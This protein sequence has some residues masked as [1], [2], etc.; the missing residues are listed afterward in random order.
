MKLLVFFFISLFLFSHSCLAA[1]I[2]TQIHVL[3]NLKNFLSGSSINEIDNFDHNEC[4]REVVELVLL[5]QALELG[6]YKEK[7]DIR[8]KVVPY[9]R[10]PKILSGDKFTVLGESVWASEAGMENSIW[11]SGPVIDEKEYQV[12][13]YT[14]PDNKKALECKNLE[15]VR[16]L[17][18]VS[19]ANYPVDWHTLKSLNLSKLYDV[20]SWTTMVYMA[21]KMR[22]DFL[23]LPFQT[24][25]GM[26]F[27]YIDKNST[28]QLEKA[29]LVPIP[30][31]KIHLNGTRH[32]IVSKKNK[33]GSKAYTA[34][35]KGLEKLNAS[36]KR[37]RAFK[38]CGFIPPETKSW[39]LLN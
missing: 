19:S 18:A 30:N 12:G 28:V 20:Q 22:A 16:K 38:E 31:V 33:D 29:F 13:L 21:D 7:I 2:L 5:Y 4:L 39:A 35:Q 34:I 15:D 14:S 36:G 8:V 6:G 37:V 9:L 26:S 10:G 3:E 27:E 11:I 23:L 24:G 32:W 17:S 25:Q 1:S